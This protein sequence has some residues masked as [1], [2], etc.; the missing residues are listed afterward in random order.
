MAKRA[1]NFETKDMTAGQRHGLG[2]SGTETA[3]ATDAV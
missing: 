2:T 3:A 1:V